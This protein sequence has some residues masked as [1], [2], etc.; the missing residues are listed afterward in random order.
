MQSKT[1]F[2]S[3]LC[4]TLLNCALFAEN[5]A[6]KKADKPNLADGGG[7]L[8]YIKTYELGAVEITAPQ[9]VD[10]NPSIN[11]IS[12][13]NIQES[14]SRN[15]A[16]AVR[17]SPGV[18]M[19]EIND[20][21]AR[22]EPSIGIR[23]YSGMQV[24]LY[25]DGI[26][27]MSI[28][29]R[30]TDFSQY[31]MQDIS[32]I[33]ISKA[34][35]SPI[36]GMSALGGAINIVSSK[37]LK[38]FELN[39]S[40]RLI[41]G[42]HRSP[43]EIRQNFGIGSNQGN[44]YFK[45]SI[46]N[47]Q[48][49]TY[50]LSSDYKGTAVQPKG[51]KINAYYRNKTAKLSFGILPNENHEYSLNY[52]YQRGEKGGFIS[53]SGG[54]WWEW[55]HY[56]K[57]TVYLLGNSYFTPNISFNT[58]LYYDNFKNT[59]H[60]FK[61]T[62][63][64]PTRPS[65]ELRFA[66]NY[67]DD[68]YGAILMLEFDLASRTNLKIGTNLKQDKH[69]ST[70][71]ND[72]IEDNL[73][74]LIS[75][76]FIQF[77]QGFGDFRFVIAASYDRLDTLK[78]AASQTTFNKDYLHSFSLQGIAYYDFAEG[79]SLHFNVGKKENLPTLKE[80]YT[81]YWGRYLP[82]PNLKPESA[83]NYELG[84]DLSLE[85][86]AFSASLFFNDMSDMLVSQTLTGT[87]AV[88]NEPDNNKCYKFLNANTGYTYGGEVSVEQGFLDE[89]VLIIG[90][91]YSYIQKKAKG[92][93]DDK[94]EYGDKITN[95]P[96]HMF[97]AKIA[98]KPIKKLEF[99][100]LSSFESARYYAGDNDYLKNN[101]YFTLDLS[102]NYELGKGLSVDAGVLNLTDRDNYINDGAWDKANHLAG[103]RW[104]AGFNYIY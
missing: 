33:Q 69:L 58:R 2:S 61:G 31:I 39:L 86:T 7:A 23:A 28:Y 94:L 82:N 98:Y 48:R 30:Q 63:T 53:S 96:N 70:D 16:Q 25:L 13:K 65:N 71:A 55:P 46:S 78:A 17:M 104:F 67:D 14:N 57:Q 100:A 81:T 95:Y 37:P 79:N 38:E 43:D 99:I 24:G 50:P 64:S 56:D 29:D 72:V 91:N 52:I 73:K 84:Y 11:I 26:P 1:I 44:Y 5:N 36:Y 45:A 87:S 6:T 83:V 8:S 18:M 35:T 102:V 20:R 27:I 97:N 66:S 88:C 15:V 10:F 103:R 60:S 62:T 74:E 3:L 19:S 41:F 75:S 68:T 80:R 59:L 76:E 9:E 101:N 90:A 77:A 4:L 21:S 47:T 40:Q 93:S 32:S 92:F 54:N 51:D 22:G 34:F 12:S 49:S 85:K 42:R 89:N